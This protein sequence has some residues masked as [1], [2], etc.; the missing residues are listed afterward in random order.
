MLDLNFIRKNPQKIKE[1]CR[2]KHISFNV[3]EF[4]DLDKRRIEALK[5]LDKIRAVKNQANKKISGEKSL[6]EKQALIGK[7]RD[8]DKEFEK[9]KSEFNE[10]D[11][12]F[13]DLLLKIPMPPA[14]DVPE[15]K[16]DEDNKEV[17]K[18]GKIPNFKFPPRDYLS[19]MKS[20][21][22]IDLE[23][24][25]KIGGFRQYLLKNEAVLLE[26]ALLHWSLDYLIKKGF[27]PIRPTTMVR[28]FTL[29]GTG[30][31]PYGREETYQL[32]KDLF[33]AGTTEVPLMAF[34]SNEI[35]NESALP[36]LYVG[37][38]DAFR[39]EAG[40]YGKDV[41]GIYRVH[42]FY[43]T[44]QVVICKNNEAESIKWHEQLL[45]NSE[46]LMQALKIPYRVVNCC[47]GDLAL[48]QGKRYDIEAWIP[49]QNKYRETHSDSYLLDFQ[50]RRLNIRYR[51]KDGK[52]KFAHSLNDTGIASPRILIS[53]LENYQRE[54]GK[55][56]VPAVLQKYLGFKIIPSQNRNSKS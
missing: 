50:T 44:E 4:L 26:Q 28:G 3:E 36:K 46:E 47:S 21:D 17:K 54:D 15:G 35:L 51:T 2:K 25:A 30:M 49:S 1:A 48:G 56:E 22:L 55:I 8:L 31:F 24:G 27:T 10:L 6:A 20:L 19:L 14:P 41:K 43:Q 18:W 32:D 5:K 9:T 33:L 12:Q 37:I 34:H 29:W 52:I 13:Q 23:R 42:A 53:L 11:R 38:S 16:T 7:M 40:S 45:K 39:K